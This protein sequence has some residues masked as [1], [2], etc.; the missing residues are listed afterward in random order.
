M[1]ARLPNTSTGTGTLEDRPFQSLI[2][3]DDRRMEYLILGDAN[4]KPCLFFPLDYGLVRWPADAE[5]EAAAMGVK[6]VV[7]IRPGYRK[8]T[9]LA[10]GISQIDTH[11]A[12]LLLLMD[13][14][15]IETAPVISLGGDFHFTVALYNAHPTRVT[16]A[17]AAA[18]VLPL[19]TS[20]QYE[21]MDKWHR[22]I[23]AGARYTPHLLP[24]MVKAG[25]ALAR[26]VGKRGF[27]HAVYGKSTADVS[28]FEIPQVYEAMVCGS[29]VCLSDTHSSHD[30][31]SREVI[32]HETYDWKENVEALKD[33]IPVHFFNGLQDP[34]VPPETLADHQ[35]NYPWIDFHVYPDAGQLL[36]FL[37]W[38]NVLSLTNRYL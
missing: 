37:K 21:R 33:R 38:R 26:R 16:A 5:A 7:P 34:Q 27:V 22:F 25:F 11:V 6:I 10:K 1:A 36:F 14:L 18:G 30:S 8:S 2:L 13:H 9:A 15:G 35:R 19:H 20:E 32:A 3:P 29:D 24:F 12:D 17:I 31:F 4:G 28:T 23:L